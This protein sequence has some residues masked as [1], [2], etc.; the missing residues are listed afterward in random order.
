[1]KSKLVIASTVLLLLFFTIPICAV[2]AQNVELL[3]EGDTFTYERYH[4]WESNDPNATPSPDADF[5]AR[6]NSVI[7][8]KIDNV[9]STEVDVH[10]TVQY[11]NGTQRTEF[12]RHDILTGYN[13]PTSIVF[14]DSR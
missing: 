1:M 6:N 7:T 5:F 9:S 10:I 13:E 11:Q 2:S 8:V 3:S 14:G 12:I 4:I